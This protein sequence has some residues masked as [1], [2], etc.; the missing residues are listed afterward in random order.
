MAGPRAAPR[1][2]AGGPAPAPPILARIA[3]PAGLI[4]AGAGAITID[5]AGARACADLAAELHLADPDRAP[6]RLAVLEPAPE[7]GALAVA[8]GLAIAAAARGRRAILVEADLGAPALARM[9]GVAPAPGLRDYL[10]QTAG[11][12]EVLRSVPVAA[13][14]ERLALVCVPAG[15]PGAAPAGGVGGGRFAALVERL[16]RAYDLVLITG[17][18]A[19]RGPDAAAI[20]GLSDAALLVAG[21]AD[22]AAAGALAGAPARGL[23]LTAQAARQGGADRRSREI[24]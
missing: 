18:A 3:D 10:E 14:G 21:S 24:R 19:E 16:P 6:R 4:G 2:G 9:L 15:E 17:P 8:I 7:Q 22:G 23:V 11:P 1:P 12:R 20:A 5:R 13:R